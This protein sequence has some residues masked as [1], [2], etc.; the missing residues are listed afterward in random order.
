MACTPAT[1]PW[2]AHVAVGFPVLRGAD[3]RL[4]EMFN[5]AYGTQ[6]MQGLLLPPAARTLPMLPVQ[7]LESFGNFMIC[8]AL[9]QAWRRRRFSGQI[10]A[11]YLALYSVLRFLLE[12][13]RGDVERGLFFG[14]STATGAQKA[15]AGGVSTSQLICVFTLAAG[16]AI[17]AWR[18]DKGIQDAPSQ[19]AQ[20]A[21]GQKSSQEP[22]KAEAT[23]GKRQA[24]ASGQGRRRRK[25]PTRDA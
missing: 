12:F 10:A 19:D 3:G 23:R 1:H 21:P 2:L 22:A 9:V 11:L 16:L 7:L 14:N 4:V 13:W 25:G 5:F 6:V 8:L 20:G 18:R 24:T 17:W 15:S